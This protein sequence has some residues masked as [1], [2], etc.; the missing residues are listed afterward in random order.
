MHL[1][2]CVAMANAR[3]LHEATSQR[4]SLAK[5][6]VTES[7]HHRKTRVGPGV[8]CLL[9]HFGID[10]MGK[11]HQVWFCICCYNEL[12]FNFGGGGQNILL[13]H[14]LIYSKSVVHK[15]IYKLCRTTQTTIHY[16][17]LSTKNA[18]QALCASTCC[19]APPCNRQLQHYHH[20]QFPQH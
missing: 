10:F 6:F 18:H 2:M 8:V 14:A 20:F 3:Q 17:N 16:L 9:P 13:Q 5:L 7:S 19:I 4:F 11:W 15:S 1:A 12:L